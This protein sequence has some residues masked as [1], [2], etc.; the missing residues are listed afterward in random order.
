MKIELFFYRKEQ[1]Q[2][3][4]ICLK[5]SLNNVKTLSN[6]QL[7]YLCIY[8]CV[9]E[10]NLKVFELHFYAKIYYQLTQLP[11]QITITPSM[12]VKYLIRFCIYRFAK[13]CFN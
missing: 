13:F 8:Q 9:I 11:L 2:I 5:D 7:F 1:K 10:S 3:K 12:L 6:G 4:C